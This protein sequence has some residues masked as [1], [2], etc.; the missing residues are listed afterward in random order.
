MEFFRSPEMMMTTR[1]SPILT[2]ATTLFFSATLLACGDA[3]EEL[4]V[5]HEDPTLVTEPMCVD[6]SASQSAG[7]SETATIALL[8]MGAED[9]RVWNV[10]FSSVDPNPAKFSK[11][12]NWPNGELEIESLER[13]EFSVN[14][15]P[16]SSGSD[17]V[18]INMNS[19]D[20]SRASASVM[21][22]ADGCPG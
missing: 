16:A 17:R 15:T 5:E 9:L 19:N 8:N 18:L 11:G 7:Q 10:D 12:Q 3:E 21:L 2:A 14:F 4:T 22:A 6:F 1:I 20:P 13:Y